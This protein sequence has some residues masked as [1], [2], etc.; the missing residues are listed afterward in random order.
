MHAHARD[1]V[2]ARTRMF[3]KHYHLFRF[4]NRFILEVL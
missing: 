1:R 4:K 3:V 2:R